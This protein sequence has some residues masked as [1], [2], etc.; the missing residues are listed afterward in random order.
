[1]DFKAGDFVHCS[2][3]PEETRIVIHP[4]GIGLG[5]TEKEI[6]VLALGESSKGYYN[7]VIRGSGYVKTT[8]SKKLVEDAKD[9]IKKSLLSIRRNG[10]IYV[11]NLTYIEITA[12]LREYEK[13]I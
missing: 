8:P 12:R 1:M 6:M 9:K 4:T 11:D 13:E 7:N 5:H 10:H 2:G 3:M